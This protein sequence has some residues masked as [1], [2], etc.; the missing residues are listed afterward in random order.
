MV[1]AALFWAATNDAVYEAT[2]PIELSFHVV[3]RKAYSIVAF[4]LVGF[5]ADKA[6]GPSGTGVL[7]GA[8]LVGAYSAAIEVVQFWIG[9]KEG[10]GWNA[11][12]TLCG[13]AGGALGALAARIRRP[14]RSA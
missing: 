6:L 1:A 11:F 7:R 8:L 2:S 3:L 9:S 4:A 14:R 13:V 10:L 12:D 5:T